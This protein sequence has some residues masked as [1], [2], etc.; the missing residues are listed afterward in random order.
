MSPG[1]LQEEVRTIYSRPVRDRRGN[2]PQ[3]RF[4]RSAG[5]PGMS[6]LLPADKGPDRAAVREHAN[7][8][9]Q[10]SA[11]AAR[12]RAGIELHASAAAQPAAG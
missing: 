2:G 3:A 4:S 1:P 12:R 8:L 11:Q 6:V 5:H 7:A 10:A 9:R